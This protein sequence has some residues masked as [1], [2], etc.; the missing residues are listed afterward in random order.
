MVRFKKNL[1]RQNVVLKFANVSP[2]VR[3][4][5]RATQ[6]EAFLLG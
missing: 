4:V 5:I 6:L 3:N 2:S 1:T